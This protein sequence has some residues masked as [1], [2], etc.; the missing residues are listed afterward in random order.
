MQ[1]VKQKLRSVYDSMYDFSRLQSTDLNFTKH[2]LVH[3]HRLARK[4]ETVHDELGRPLIVKQIRQKPPVFT[5]EKLIS[6]Q[7]CDQLAEYHARRKAAYEEKEL[8]PVYC[9][10]HERYISHVDVAKSLVDTSSSGTKSA[11]Q[12]VNG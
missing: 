11:N 5:I 8:H 4:K 7:E 12:H 1:K 10:Q 2:A 6:E 3:L 9:F